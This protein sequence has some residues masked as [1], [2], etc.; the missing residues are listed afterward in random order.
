MTHLHIIIGYKR[1]ELTSFPGVVPNKS[2]DHSSAYLCTFNAFIVP[3]STSVYITL[4]GRISTN[5]K[6]Q[7]IWKEAAVT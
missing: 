6:F 2:Q 5:N 7:G 1:V 4:S 3:V